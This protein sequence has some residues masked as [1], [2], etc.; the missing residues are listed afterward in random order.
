MKNKVFIIQLLYALTTAIVL[1]IIAMLFYPGGTFFDPHAN[2]YRFFEN[3][4]SHLG[5]EVSY[6]GIDNT[7]SKILFKSSIYLIGGSFIVYF[8]AIPFYFKNHRKSY[9]LTKASTLIV[10]IAAIAFVGIG[11]FSIDPATKYYHLMCVKLSFYS[12][13]I[14]CFLQ[15]FAVYFHPLMTKK[16]FISYLSF[17]TILLAYNLLIQ[18]GPKP[19]SNYDSLILQVTAQKIIATAFFVNFYI[20]GFELVKVLKR[21]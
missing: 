12:F 3:F 6:I 4:L 21:G 16:M 8:F 14:S 11:Y 13:F 2:S 9:R 5:R 18:F 20:Q 17:T 7:V 10:L 15:T 19:N 1:L